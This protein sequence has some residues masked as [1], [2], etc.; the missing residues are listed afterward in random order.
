MYKSILVPVDILEKELTK[1]MIPNIEFLGRSSSAR[2]HLFHV[3]HLA[4]TMI[5]AYSFGVEAI[6]DQAVKKTEAW[7]QELKLS[8]DLPQEQISYSTTFGNPKDEIIKEAHEI[9]ADLIVIGSHRPGLKTQVLGSNAASIVR[10]A[11][12]SVLVVR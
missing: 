10:H 11:K 7:L 8:F 9:D 1:K 3:L 4:S 5:N 6:Q 2:I 12:M